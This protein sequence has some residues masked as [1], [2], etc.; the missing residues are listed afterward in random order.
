MG[1]SGVGR[2]GQALG[3]RQV[4]SLQATWCLHSAR[5]CW[6]VWGLPATQTKGTGKCCWPC[7][8]LRLG[9]RGLRA[10]VT[11][12]ADPQGEGPSL[13]CCGRGAYRW[14]ELHEGTWTLGIGALCGHR[15]LGVGLSRGSLADT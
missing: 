10:L 7:P 8:V 14:M 11:R 6:P 5:R 9:Q 4:L 1:G 13:A 2:S 3:L 12:A 15:W